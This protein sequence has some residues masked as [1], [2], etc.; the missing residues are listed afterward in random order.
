MNGIYITLPFVQFLIGLVLTSVVFLSAP[1][2]KLN[3]VFAL[4]LIAMAAWGITIFG[5]RDAFPDAKRAYEIERVVL[6]VIP[7]MSIL[8]YH[9]VYLFA[10]VPRSRAYLVAFYGMG[11]T[12]AAFSL[13][14]WSATGMV[15]KFYGFAPDL[16][17]AFPLVLA[18]A[19]PPVALA[20]YDLTRA[21][22]RAP[23]PRE[24]TQLKMLRLG[25]FAAVAGGTSD[26]LPSLGLNVYPMG[27]L[28][29]I[30]FGIIATWAVTR[31]RMMDLRLVLRQGLAYTLIS[32]FLSGIYGASIAAVWLIVRDYSLPAILLTA[33]GTVLILGLFVQPILGRVQGIVD[34][35]F[36]RE[37]QGR[38]EAM[39]RL[40]ADV[41]DIADFSLIVNQLVH[42]VRR[43]LQ[44]DWVAI[45]LPDRSGRTFETVAD[46]R[47]QKVE[48]AIPAESAV[49][50]WFDHYEQPLSRD[51][52][53]ADPSLQALTEEESSALGSLS[54][55]LM[56]PL[57]AKGE[58]SGILALGPK[59]VGRDYSA[60]DVQF[61]MGVAGQTAV[62]I[63]NARMYA[64]EVE[65]LAELE[66]LGSL[67]SNLLQTVSHELKSPITA[68]KLST[69]MLEVTL[70]TA[71][72]D[73]RRDRMIHTLK[74]SIERLERLTREALDYAAMQSAQLE[75]Q[76]SDVSLAA[77]V[78]ESVNLLRPTILARGQQL[79]VDTDPSMGTTRADG[80]RVERIITNLLTNASKYSPES[81]QIG[82]KIYGDGDDHVIE[83]SDSG[84]GIPEDEIELI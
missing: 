35:L 68:I 69:E 62:A 41:R 44:S 20:I 72:A 64:N 10:R 18:A 51:D 15:V 22:K 74:N 38:L 12:S 71:E 6:A 80:R 17:W 53:W 36:F 84:R 34:T 43:T 27:V 28:G 9:F 29:N 8:F 63:E 78:D 39:V 49:S 25:A 55:D 83:I 45:I 54:A 33:G 46:S 60:D 13:L 52:L 77:V 40:N 66:R 37:K 75:L 32:A 30:A 26:F 47:G 65:R 81:G 5:M 23:G 61:V 70:V 82:I 11:V 31:Y 4:F 1:R 19:Y 14:G 57:R 24:E 56:V 76:L 73:H 21:A 67:K 2:D 3:R 42:G 7:F 58:L 50:T 59:L 16:G 48:F 79:S